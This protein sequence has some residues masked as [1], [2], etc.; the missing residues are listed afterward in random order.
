VDR[1]KSQ[2]AQIVLALE[3]LTDTLKE[4]Y[5]SFF[6]SPVKLLIGNK[7]S[8]AIIP[9]SHMWSYI[10]HAQYILNLLKNIDQIGYDIDYVMLELSFFLS[11]LGL[12]MSINGE[13]LLKGPMSHQV[14]QQRTE[15]LQLGMNEQ[16]SFN[17][18]GG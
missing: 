14:M 6:E 12:S 15:L 4:P 7:I 8:L 10:Q 9:P 11:R 17:V 16:G 13:F 3:P 1:L 2:W 5:K 18:R